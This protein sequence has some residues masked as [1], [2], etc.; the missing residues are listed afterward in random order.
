MRTLLFLV[1]T[2]PLSAAQM[3]ADDSF[4]LRME[5]SNSQGNSCVLLQRTGSFHLEINRDQQA[6]ILQGRMRPDQLLEIERTIS[7]GAL[8]SLSQRQ[9]EEPLL[10]TRRD[11]LQ[12][13]IFRKDHWQDLLFES[14]DSQEPYKQSLR[15][16]T[17]W[18][19]DLRTLPHRELTEDEGRNNCLPPKPIVLKRRSSDS[20][21]DS[22]DGAS[23]PK[24][25]ISARALR[26]APPV[27][28]T[29]AISPLLRVSSLTI[30]S[31]EALEECVFLA[32]DGSFHFER[33]TQKNGRKQLNTGIFAGKITDQEISQL[34][35]VL[36]DPALKKLGH[37]EPS[38]HTSVAMLG[39][40]VEISI[41]RAGG[42]QRLVLSS[43]FNRR[44]MGFFYGGDGDI[45]VARP[46]LQFLAEHVENKQSGAL[47]PALRNRCTGP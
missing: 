15:A 47:D 31:R 40:V 39:D 36:A 10:I 24:P 7:D 43:G 23:A 16:L 32:D 37:R 13:N 8:A 33:R 45:G 38:G 14:T 35:E 6:K 25:A 41:A 3:N 34:R 44:Q 18:L 19:N 30:G 12:L 46:L 42:T 17:R 22:V 29:A 27:A 11:T 20:I 9:I 28:T 2:V 26:T 21:P 5:H 4:L 1:V